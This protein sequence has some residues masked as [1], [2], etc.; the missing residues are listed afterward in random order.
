MAYLGFYSRE[1]E[2]GIILGGINKYF[3]LKF[4]VGIDEYKLKDIKFLILLLCIKY[5]GILL[6]FCISYIIEYQ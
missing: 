2:S 1:R 3:K 4:F 5:I 6:I